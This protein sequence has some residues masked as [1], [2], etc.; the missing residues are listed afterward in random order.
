MTAKAA[1]IFVV[2]GE[3]SGDR[4]GAA[5]IRALRQRD[6]ALQFLGLGGHD[7]AGE[8]IQNLFPI[9]ELAI[10]GLAAIPRR[11]PAILRRIRQTAD[12]AIAAKP[13]ALVI[14][15]SPD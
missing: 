14:I 12:A 10:V 15:D 8:G 3:E 11:L 5:L 7:M 1:T 2:A 4:L 6:S 9:D 13:D